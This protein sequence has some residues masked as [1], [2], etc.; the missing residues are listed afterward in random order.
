[1]AVAYQTNKITYVGNGAIQDF[2]IPFEILDTTT[3]KIWKRDN[4]VPLIP[5]V[6]LLAEG[7]FADYQVTG[8]NPALGIVATGIHTTIAYGA[9]IQI[10]MTRVLPRTQSAS[11]SDAFAPPAKNYEVGLDKAE[12]QIQQLQEQI[13]RAVK[14]DTTSPTSGPVFPEPAAQK[15]LGWD[16]TGTNLKLYTAGEIGL[17]LNSNIISTA[18]VAFA[19]DAAFVTNKTAAAS[20]GDAYYNTTSNRVRVFRNG[21]W[22]FLLQTE[23][24]TTRVAPLSVV[25]GTGVPTISYC[26]EQ[27]FFV[28]TAAGNVVVTAAP[29]IAVGN[30]VGQKLR[31]VGTSNANYPTFAD[32]NGLSLNGSWDGQQDSVLVLFWDGSNWIEESRR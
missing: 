31:L 17:I 10:I 25:A 24:V 6:T 22:E 15:F 28:S 2:P 11:F 7:P 18:F 13:D 26:Q 32:G 1:M 21:N 19:N 5:V 27:M 8:A 14:M 9:S 23:S 29:Q 3:L 16:L 30:Y 4:T 20:N 12:M